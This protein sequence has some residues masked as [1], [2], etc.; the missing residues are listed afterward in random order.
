MPAVKHPGS[1]CLMGSSV[2][3]GETEAT[4]TFTGTSSQNAAGYLNVAMR[5]VG[6]R[7]T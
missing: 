5:L 1:E 4:V 7:Q 3:R 6:K 2:A